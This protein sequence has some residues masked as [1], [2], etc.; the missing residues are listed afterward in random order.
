MTENLFCSL[1]LSLRSNQQLSSEKDTSLT[2]IQS[3]DE[4]F[5]LRGEPQTGATL[6]SSDDHEARARVQMN[7]PPLEAP[8]MW[9]WSMST[10][11]LP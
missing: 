6:A 7:I 8:D 9:I 1:N 11:N 5:Y 4:F 2:I 10:Q 3:H